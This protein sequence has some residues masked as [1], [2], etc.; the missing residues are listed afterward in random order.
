MQTFRNLF[1]VA[2]LIVGADCLAETKGQ[3][4]I[5]NYSDPHSVD[6]ALSLIQNAG[7][8]PDWMHLEP[9]APRA[10]VGVQAL[11]SLDTELTEKSG[12]ATKFLLYTDNP[13]AASNQWQV[14]AR[15]DI[16]DAKH[17][18]IVK[19]QKLNEEEMKLP[20]CNVKKTNPSDC[21][22]SNV[23]EDVVTLLL[24]SASAI[25]DEVARLHTS[26]DLVVDHRAVK[27]VL[28]E[29]TEDEQLGH[30]EFSGLVRGRNE[31]L[32]A[33]DATS[34]F[35]IRMANDGEISLLERVPD[36]S[37]DGSLIKFSFEQ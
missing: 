16:P 21:R 7:H 22:L 32:Q 27:R 26:E 17:G 1:L 9:D 10:A 33:P 5:L 28:V 35:V 14:P 11:E 25:A 13:S 20:L 8:L 15:D 24:R 37:I 4:L 34:I 36:S 31:Q 6:F 12:R 23:G 30:V 29:L 18:G 19:S 2:L 3:R